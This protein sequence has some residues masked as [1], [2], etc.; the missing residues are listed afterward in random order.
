MF[1][2]CFIL[3]SRL[4]LILEDLLWVLTD[5]Q[6]RAALY[7]VESLAGMVQKATEVSRKR[8]AARKIEVCVLKFL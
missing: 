4:V 2:D 1:A 8:K 3:G 7:F 5:S 6:L